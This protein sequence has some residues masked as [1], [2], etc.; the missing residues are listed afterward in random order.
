[1]RIQC[2]VYISVIVYFF[3]QGFKLKEN[4]NR[5]PVISLAD[6][7]SK[8][9]IVGSFSETL[10]LFSWDKLVEQS[11]DNV[12]SNTITSESFTLFLPLFKARILSI[13]PF[14]LTLNDLEPKFEVSWL[15]ATVVVSFFAFFS[16]TFKSTEGGVLVSQGLHH[17]F[18]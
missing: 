9:L 13:I 6:S 15:V 12:S 10:K 11:V 18:V 1:M 16:D 7:S 4:W 3:F 8:V 14:L 2:I 17:L 5:L